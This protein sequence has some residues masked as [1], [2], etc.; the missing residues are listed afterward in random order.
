MKIRCFG[1]DGGVHVHVC[2]WGCWWCSGRT[3]VLLRAENPGQ[4]PHRDLWLHEPRK[5]T[6]Y[7]PSRGLSPWAPGQQYPELDGFIRSPAAIIGKPQVRPCPVCPCRSAS[8]GLKCLQR[9]Q[10]S[11]SPS[12]GFGV[13]PLAVLLFSGASRLAFTYF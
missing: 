9:P 3:G 2:P 1:M 5:P 11:L 6:L 4:S 8:E 12:T 13:P 10:A 7:T